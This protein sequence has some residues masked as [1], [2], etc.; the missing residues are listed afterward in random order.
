[1]IYK[2]KSQIQNIKI[3]RFKKSIILMSI[4]FVISNY[5]VL[6]ND[7]SGESFYNYLFVKFIGKK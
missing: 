6:G 3:L 5:I 7:N 2:S 1:M 4:V